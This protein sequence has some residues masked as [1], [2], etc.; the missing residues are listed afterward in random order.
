MFLF[1][2][3]F[4]KKVLMCL[5]FGMFLCVSHAQNEDVTTEVKKYFLI[6]ASTTNYEEALSSATSIAE[7]LKLPL[8][9]RKLEYSDENLGLTWSKEECE[10]SNWGYPCYVA[11]GRY[12]DGDFVSIEWS[13]AYGG[14]SKGYYIVIVSGNQIYDDSLKD[15]LRKTK[16]FVPSA[17]IK[18]SMV[19]MGCLH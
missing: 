5:F 13:S 8:D 16:E 12:D 15:L 6:A 1:D 19:Y 3:S 7:K 18:S 10:G 11:R 9:L 14:F 2:N 4:E 17:Y